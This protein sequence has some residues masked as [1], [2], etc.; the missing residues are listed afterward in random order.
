MTMEHVPACIDAS[1]Y[2]DSVC[3]LAGWASKR[4]QMPV[5]LLH[6]VQR[7]DAVAARGDLSGAIG[8]GVKTS[9]MDELVE[10]EAA[11]AKLQVER[12]RML[13]AAGEKRLREAGA[14]DGQHLT[15]PGG[16]VGNILEREEDASARR[17]A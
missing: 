15:P 13:L 8:L 5:E 1:T 12:G 10:L 7:K 2:A 6:V 14:L 4:L 3:D 9:L 11:D 17:H 16:S